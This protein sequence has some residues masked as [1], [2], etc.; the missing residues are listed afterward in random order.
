MLKGMQ[1][2]CLE[3]VSSRGSARNVLKYLLSIPKTWEYTQVHQ[4][5]GYNSCKL[6]LYHV[7]DSI[8]A[9][10]QLEKWLN[11]ERRIEIVKLIEA[12]HHDQKVHKKG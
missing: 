4:R 3:Y 9:T 2:W 6:H 11:V 10:N 7:Y 8:M 12:N 5:L 1:K